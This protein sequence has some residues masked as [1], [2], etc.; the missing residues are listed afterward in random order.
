M[1]RIDCVVVG[2]GVIGLAVSRALALA[3][4][5]VLVLERAAAIGTETSSRNSEVIHAGLYYT[6]GS[7]KA[8]WCVEG[9]ERLYAF[10]AD[11]G[12]A[13][14]AIGK[15]LVATS[16]AQ[17]AKLGAIMENAQRNGVGDL[18]W[19][20]IDEARALEPEVHCVAAIFS[21]S[22]G[23]VDSHGFMLAL[24]GDLEDAGGVIAFNTAVS[25]GRAEG[26]GITIE[27]SELKLKAR[28]VVDSAG[29]YAPALARAIEG[30]PARLIPAPR[31]AKGNYFALTGARAPFKHLI[32]PMPE[33]AGLGIHATL[34]LGGGVR[35]GPDVEWVDRVD[36]DVDP[37]RAA[38]FE[39]AIRRYWPGLPRGALAP[40]YSGIRP[41]IVD[42]GQPAADFMISGPPDHGIPGLWHLFGIES[43]GLTASLA[44]AADLSQRMQI[45]STAA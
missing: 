21:P 9:R 30:M 22:S 5:E 29:L 42:P 2:A 16:E 10:C 15:L 20:T 25:G 6:P 32:Y 19:L 24:Q 34:D 13:A 27:T 3:G 41:K 37:N 12:I 43:P 17:I 1:E 23:I 44:L 38:H 45:A 28:L 7:L 33:E 26:D 11:R 36:Y 31:F 8:R 40:S 4:R 39:E 35:F 14:R 18:R